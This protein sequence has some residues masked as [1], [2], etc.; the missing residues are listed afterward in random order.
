MPISNILQTSCTEV[1]EDNHIAK[2]LLRAKRNSR[3][4]Q[5]VY[6]LQDQKKSSKTADKGRLEPLRA[7]NSHFLEFSENQERFGGKGNPKFLMTLYANERHC[8]EGTLKGT[9][10]PPCSTF[11]S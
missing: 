9:E 4:R 6:L 3:I 8:H 11:L 5:S 1:E 2:F 10:T 7:R